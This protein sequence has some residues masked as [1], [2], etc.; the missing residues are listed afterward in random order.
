MAAKAQSGQRS[1]FRFKCDTSAKKLHQ[2]VR[3]GVFGSIAGHGGAYLQHLVAEAASR[4]RILHRSVD[5]IRQFLLRAWTDDFGQFTRQDPSR[6]RQSG[7]LA[8]RRSG[9]THRRPVQHGG[10]RRP[11][12]SP[13]ASEP[14]VGSSPLLLKNPLRTPPTHKQ[15]RVCGQ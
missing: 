15:K 6:R 7:L 9:P 11:R 4:A 1:W 13:D 10:G 14:H 8:G 3:K 2:R 12:A 5:Q